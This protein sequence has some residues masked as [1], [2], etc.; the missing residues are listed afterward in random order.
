MTL[1]LGTVCFGTIVLTWSELDGWVPD[2]HPDSPVHQARPRL[3]D[4]GRTRLSM[5]NSK[6]HIHLRFQA[7]VIA[8]QLP[9]NTAEALLVL[10]YARHMEG[11]FLDDRSGVS[12][13]VSGTTETQPAPSRVRDRFTVSD[14]MAERA[15]SSRAADAGCAQFAERD[16]LRVGRHRRVP[17]RRPPAS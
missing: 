2:Y 13:N 17:K 6:K 11:E 10:D 12:D 7:V 16:F 4:R 9:D 3:R 15:R 1:Y 5:S 14:R 8:S